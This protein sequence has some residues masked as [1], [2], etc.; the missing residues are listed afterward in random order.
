MSCVLAVVGQQDGKLKKSTLSALGAA[1]ILAKELG[2]PAVGVVMGSN[3]SG[4]AD[5]LAG[6]GP[7]KVVAVDGP[8]LKDYLG[9]AYA[10]ALGEL[11]KKTGAKALIAPAD[12]FGKDCLPRVATKLK[13]PL[14]TEVMEVVSGQSGKVFKR[15]M[16]A[17]NVIATV[18]LEG[19]PVL[20][21]VRTT[22]FAAPGKAGSKAP[23]E[24]SDPGSPASNGASFKEFQAIKSERPE[25][26]DAGVVV[27]GGRGLKTPEDFK[28]LMEPLAD[29][30][31]AA[32]GATRAVVDAGW[33]PNDWQVGQTGK[34]VAPTLYIAFGISGAIQHVAGMKDSKVIV[35]VNRDGDAPIFEVA[36]YGIVGDAFKVIPELTEKFKSL[37][38]Q[39]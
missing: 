34:T 23:V 6:F 4:A 17:G 28:K 31:G 1:Q 22:A 14:A 25:L 21:T 39:Q 11:V 26:V 18:Q 35:A 12:S 38:A 33:V 37:K 20:L 2:V 32:I 5:E 8:S 19:Q 10:S 13:A 36:D 9:E 27:S 15:P 16:Y 7:S 24:K 3:I 30:L 29:V